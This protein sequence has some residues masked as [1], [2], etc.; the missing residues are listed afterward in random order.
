MQGVLRVPSASATL[1]RHMRDCPRRHGDAVKALPRANDRR[2][3]AAEVAAAPV[4]ADEV[5]I[6]DSVCD[7]RF[8]VPQTAPHLALLAQVPTPQAV[9]NDAR[10]SRTLTLCAVLH[11]AL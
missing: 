3:S 8:H 4:A 7:G 1:R 11:P 2:T 5:T 9:A 6:R 10:M